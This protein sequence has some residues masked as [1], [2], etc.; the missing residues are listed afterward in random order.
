MGANDYRVGNSKSGR[1]EFIST[2]LLSLAAINLN[3]SDFN[4]T[5]PSSMM[6]TSGKGASRHFKIAARLE[7][8]PGKNIPEK[9]SNAERFGFN[10][11]SLPGRYLNSYQTELMEVFHDLP[12]PLVVLLGVPGVAGGGLRHRTDP[13]RGRRHHHPGAVMT[14]GRRDGARGIS[15]AGN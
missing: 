14:T 4:P 13:D 1:R 7:M 8:L 10:G 2:A 12:L 11:I 3:P 5:G 6:V 15:G 9:I